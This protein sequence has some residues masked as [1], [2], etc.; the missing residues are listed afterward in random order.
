MNLS[1]SFEVSK[2]KILPKNYF[3]WIHKWGSS[4]LEMTP[5]TH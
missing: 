5:K 1:L 2:F 3:I 4:Q